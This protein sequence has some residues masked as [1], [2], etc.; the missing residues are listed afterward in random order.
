M[1]RKSIDFQRICGFHVQTDCREP[2][3]WSTTQDRAL[4]TQIP[5]RIE[6]KNSLK[7]VRT[8]CIRPPAEAMKN[9]G[10]VINHY[11]NMEPVDKPAMRSE[12]PRVVSESYLALVE[13]NACNKGEPNCRV[14]FSESGLNVVYLT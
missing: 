12:I 13:A 14:D 11:P 9:L 10:A 8:S 3:N 2:L 1:F 4:S 7:S 5:H 6:S